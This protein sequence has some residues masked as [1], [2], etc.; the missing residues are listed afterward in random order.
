[1]F[2]DFIEGVQKGLPLKQN[3]W[4]GL[5]SN[6]GLLHPCGGSLRLDLFT[7]EDRPKR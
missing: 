7:L 5:V 1:M 3:G 6:T 2:K 4:N